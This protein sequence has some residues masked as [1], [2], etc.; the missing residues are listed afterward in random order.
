MPPARLL[1]PAL[2]LLPLPASAQQVIVGGAAPTAGPEA[3]W[4]IGA[5]IGLMLALLGGLIAVL[6]RSIRRAAEWCG[7]TLPGASAAEVQQARLKAFALVQ[8]MPLGVPEGTVRACIGLFIIVLGIAAIVFQR[9]LGLG[10]TGELAGLLGTVLGFYF[11]TRTS[12]GEREAAREATRTA[13]EKTAEAE[14]ATRRAEAAVAREGEI[15]AEAARAAER[16]AEARSTLGEAERIADNARRIAEV[17]AEVAPDLPLARTAARVA[18]LADSAIAVARSAAGGTADGG[19]VAEAAHRAASLVAEIRGEDPLAKLVSGA[20]GG[21]AGA[22]KGAAGLASAVGGPLGLAG[23]VL[24]GAAGA[25]RIGTEHYRR[26]V[27]RVLDRPYGL[28]LYPEGLTDAAI[29]LAALEAAPI[30][31]RIYGEAI[32]APRDLAAARA[33]LAAAL[34]PEAAALIPA[35]SGA[36]RPA[37]V[38]EGGAFATT[39]ELEEGIQQFRR[40]VLE[41]ILDQADSAPVTVTLPGRAIAVPQATLRQAV[42]AA[43]EDPGGAAALDQLAL[44]GA[45][46]AREPGVDVA[47]S[48]ARAAGGTP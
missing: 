45:K 9:Q 15:R 18:T 39:I 8:A 38:G 4:F 2:V 11:G 44:A 37:P 30:F 3:A 43:R 7:E 19:S 48:L 24:I 41:R 31:R 47:A 36:L 29:A 34:S 17:V 26:W 21:L 25:F 13:A 42:D 27:A 35:G 33:L 6:H 20:A 23:A 16:E 28:D 46:L 1:A 32:L 5:G 12:A 14:A 10:T 22:L 40:A